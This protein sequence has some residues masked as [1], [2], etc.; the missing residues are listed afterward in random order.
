M[1]TAPPEAA[2]T[3]S[4]DMNEYGRAQVDWLTEL[5]TGI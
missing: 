3:A 4:T 5:A 2:V 1:L